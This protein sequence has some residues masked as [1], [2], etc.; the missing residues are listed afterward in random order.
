MPAMITAGLAGSR[1]RDG[2]DALL[3]VR[4][5]G[6]VDGAAGAVGGVEGRRAA[7]AAPRG[8]GA[9]APESETEA[10]LGR[11]G[12][13]YRPGTAATPAAADGTAGHAGHAVALA[14]AVCPLALDLPLPQR[15]SAGRCPDRGADQAD[16]TGE[17]GQ[18]IQAD[19]G[20]VAWPRVPGRGIHRASGS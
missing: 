17:S 6:R 16:G 4:P 2:T 19:P 7:G 11:P 1:A 9:A 12:G 18:G 5:P 15:P 3:D 14:P 10:G 13:T 20:R 8:R